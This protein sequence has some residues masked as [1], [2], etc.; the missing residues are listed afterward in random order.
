MSTFGTRGI[1]R[2]TPLAMAAAAVGLCT[3]AMSPGTASAAELNCAAPAGAESIAGDGS[4]AC[5]VRADEASRAISRALDGVAFSRAVLGGTAVSLAQAG[6][7]A[8]AETESGGVGAVS[9]GADSVSIISADP[10]AIAVAMSMTRGQTFVGTVDEGV[11]CDAGMGM[12]VNL[13]TGQVCLSDGINSWST[14]IA[15]P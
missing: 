7:V 13:T 3:A 5:G 2:K 1:R 4:G 10:G 12:A 14:R 6:G 11:R 15:L 9:L 8:A